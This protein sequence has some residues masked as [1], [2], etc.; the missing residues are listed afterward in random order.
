MSKKTVN[1]I[2]KYDIN[3]EDIKKILLDS[4]SF[5]LARKFEDKQKLTHNRN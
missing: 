1:I 2:F 5:F 3:G 4:F